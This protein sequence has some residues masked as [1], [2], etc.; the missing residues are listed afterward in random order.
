M[1]E[2]SLLVAALLVVGIAILADP[3]IRLVG[4]DEYADAASSCG[5]RRL[6]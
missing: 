4:G 1:T 2:A 6:R 3:G 5:S